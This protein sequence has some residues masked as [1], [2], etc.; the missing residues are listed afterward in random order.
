MRSL[1]VVL[2][3]LVALA[4]CTARRDAAGPAQ[5]FAA[6]Q[7]AAAPAV[8]GRLLDG[9]SFDLASHHGDVV[10]VNFWASWCAPCRDEVADLVA[11]YEAT[12]A[13]GVTFLGVDSRDQS[14]QAL[15]FVAG[16]HVSYPSLFDPAGR[17]A[18]SFDDLPSVLPST[19][20]I[21]RQ[22]HI[23]AVF[24]NRVFREDLTALVRRV[25]AESR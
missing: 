23:A 21:D 24:R 17:V 25:A 6:G 9:G 5:T 13:E 20:V 14:D 10:V 12:R 3:V 11:T 16:H 1:V 4:G 18:L 15:A 2:L 8:T 19:L 7:R 22:G